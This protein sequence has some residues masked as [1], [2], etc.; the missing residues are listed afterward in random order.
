MS[1]KIAYQGVICRNKRK[2]GP[3]I[4]WQ[5]VTILLDKAKRLGYGEVRFEEETM[6]QQ[7][8]RQEA[9]NRAI[10]NLRRLQW[11]FSNNPT[12]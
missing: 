5:N 1:I 6:T 8:I 10:G 2:N 7:E 4:V 12:K 3:K 11:K 9:L